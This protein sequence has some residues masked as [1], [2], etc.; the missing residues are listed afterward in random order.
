MAKIMRAQGGCKDWADTLKASL[1]I[2]INYF[3]IPEQ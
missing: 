3:V 2:A 1:K